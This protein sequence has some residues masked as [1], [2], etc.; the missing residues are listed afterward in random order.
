MPIT[1]RI[2]AAL[3]KQRLGSE[4]VVMIDGPA[5]EHELV[6]QGRTEGQAIVETRDY[7]VVAAPVGVAV[8]RV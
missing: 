3:Q 2:V 6:L 8:G 1:M 5:P 7:D 4:I